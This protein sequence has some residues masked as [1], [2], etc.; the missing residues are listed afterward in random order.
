MSTQ[1]TKRQEDILKVPPIVWESLFG[2]FIYHIQM[3]S[4]MISSDADG[5]RAALE[6][7]STELSNIREFLT[8]G[9]TT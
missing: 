8:H 1:L 6:N 3:A 7:V 4:G 5:A 9:D 2:G